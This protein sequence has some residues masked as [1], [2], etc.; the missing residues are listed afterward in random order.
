L[1]DITF[2][3]GP[4]DGSDVTFE[5][6][7][8]LDSDITFEVGAGVGDGITFE[9]GAELGD[10]ITFE[11]GAAIGDEITFEV[12]PITGEPGPTGS[13]GPS[14]VVAADAPATYN[15]GTQ[16]IG[17]AL[18]TTGSTATAGND[19]RLS[20]ARTP[21]GSAGGDLTGTYPNPTI[22]ASKVTSSNIVDGT[23]V[24]ADINAGAAIAATKLATP[25]TGLYV[26]GGIYN[27]QVRLG[28]TRSIAPGSM[29][30]WALDFDG[31]V[32][33]DGLSINVVTGGSSGVAH[34]YVVTGSATTGRPTS[35]ST[36]L[37]TCSNVAVATNATRATASF[38]SSATLAVT[39]GR[40][41]G[42]VH[43]VTGTAA[44]QA[45]DP[46]TQLGPPYAAAATY[47]ANGLSGIG[48]SGA[49]TSTTALTSLSGVTV[50]IPGA[51]VNQGPVIYWRAH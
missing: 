9:V 31:P 29:Y 24:D 34:M 19:S 20:D 51:D 37:A 48:A 23:I 50:S 22:G 26:S 32:T 47:S 5:V 1:T 17:V 46:S 45:C 8:D 13:T 39:R 21:T 4:E 33:I 6:G 16:T 25:L 18:G 3:V 14:G 12:G 43:A 15:S 7:A 11:V 2:D 44:Y 42:V 38:D 27:A 28:G 40:L 41:W 49:G 36:I 10:A 30:F 35:A